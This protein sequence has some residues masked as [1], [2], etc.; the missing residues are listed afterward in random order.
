MDLFK[1]DAHFGVTLDKAV[2]AAYFGGSH[3]LLSFRQSRSV[4]W[5]RAGECWNAQWLVAD[6]L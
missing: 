5:L 2:G 3:V 6:G 4:F 1:A